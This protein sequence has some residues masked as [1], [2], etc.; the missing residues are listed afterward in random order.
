MSKNRIIC[1]RCLEGVDPLALILLNIDCPRLS[2][3]TAVNVELDIIVIRVSLVIHGT[4]ADTGQL[5]ETL[6]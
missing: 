4:R 2:I 1:E 3:S 6:D 5:L